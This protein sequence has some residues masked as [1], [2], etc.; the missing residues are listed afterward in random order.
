VSDET[1][2]TAREL[3][4]QAFQK[5]K[6][7]DGHYLARLLTDWLG[8]H[9][10]VVSIS[11]HEPSTYH[12]RVTSQAQAQKLIDNFGGVA[13]PREAGYDVSGYVVDLTS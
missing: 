5:A 3:V 9:A 13:E 1:E 8:L 12:I 2:I 11:A 10:P 4:I 6:K 7:R